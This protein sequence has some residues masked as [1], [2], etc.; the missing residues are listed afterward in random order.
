MKKNITTTNKNGK[1]ALR[2]SR[3]L[4]TIADKILAK[5]TTK[6][7]VEDDSW[8]QRLWDWADENN[9]FAMRWID[10]GWDYE[11]NDIAFGEFNDCYIVPGWRG[12]TEDKTELMNLTE[13]LFD[14]Y[15]LS[16]LPK[17]IG[18]LKNLKFLELRQNNLSSLPEEI[19]QL[20]NLIYLNLW[21]NSLKTIPKGIGKLHKL[22]S[23][24]LAYN[25]IRILPKEIANLVNLTEL[26]LNANPNLTLAT[27]QKKWI[28]N[29][30]KNGCNVSMDGDLL[31]RV[32]ANSIP[33]IDIN[34]EELPF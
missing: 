21:L 15:E 19:G 26:W 3:N 28:L 20:T 1:L 27:E 14:R 9:A 31:D 2:K 17:E 34:E 22:D 25:E 4:M 5:K 32:K 12:L 23:L 30:Q 18:N 29:L 24:N 33:I 13:L 11:D 7:L 16:E 6:N 10:A 8:M